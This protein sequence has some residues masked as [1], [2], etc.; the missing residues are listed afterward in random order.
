MPVLGRINP[1]LGSAQFVPRLVQ[2]KMHAG[3]PLHLTSQMC[4]GHHKNCPHG[5]QRLEAFAQRRGLP[6]DPLLLSST[7]RLL[8][9]LGNLCRPLTVSRQHG[10]PTI[11]CIICPRS[12]HCKAC[13]RCR[14]KARAESLNQPAP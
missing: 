14:A 1:I 5:R 6:A 11:G 3:G 9:D 10:R 12:M 4:L 2:G 13:Y 8:S 7:N